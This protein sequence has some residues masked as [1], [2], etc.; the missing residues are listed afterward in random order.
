MS[1][2]QQQ[3]RVL[4]GKKSLKVDYYAEKQKIKGKLLLL[5]I[6]S[7]ANYKYDSELFGKRGQSWRFPERSRK[8]IPETNEIDV[9]I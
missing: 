9:H 3:N 8:C 2:L 4:K 5:R 6:W 1:I 7:I